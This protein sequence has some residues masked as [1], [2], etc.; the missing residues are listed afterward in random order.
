MPLPVKARF[1][2]NTLARQ[3]SLR[4]GISERAAGGDRGYSQSRNTCMMGGHSAMSGILTL[5]QVVQR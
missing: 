3:F 2:S 5:P 4:S 1:F